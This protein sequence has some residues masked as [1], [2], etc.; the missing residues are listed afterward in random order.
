MDYEPEE[1]KRRGSISSAANLPNGKAQ[2]QFYCTPGDSNLA[3]EIK[4]SMS[5]WKMLS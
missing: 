3:Y 4:C 5:V 2:N 1:Q